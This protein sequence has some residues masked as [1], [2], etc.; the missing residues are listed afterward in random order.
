MAELQ[1]TL[2]TLGVYR[3]PHMD[4]EL[5]QQLHQY[6]FFGNAPRDRSRKVNEFI[7][8]CIPLVLVEVSLAD[9]DERFSV[10]DF[11]QE[12]PEAPPKAW[13]AAYDE[14]VLSFDGSQLPCPKNSLHAR[15][16]GLCARI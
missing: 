10:A 7:E 1:P 14:A 9:L 11:T 12:M 15:T 4:S 3:V 13:Q 16:K 6:Y 2:I 5:R 8:T